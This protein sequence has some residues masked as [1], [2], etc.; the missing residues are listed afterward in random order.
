MIS[1]DLKNILKIWLIS[2]IIYVVM[3]VKEKCVV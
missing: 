1:S 2:Y 3:I